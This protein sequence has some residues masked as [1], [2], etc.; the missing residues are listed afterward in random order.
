MSDTT[1][2]LWQNYF[3]KDYLTV[4]RE[5]DKRLNE[6]VIDLHLSGLC[7]A[8][9]GRTQIA[10]T[11]L[12][13][14]ADLSFNQ[15]HMLANA[16]VALL[17]A[18]DPRACEE[19]SRI[20]TE[21]HPKNAMLHFMLGNS[22]LTQ[23]RFAEAVEPYRTSLLL[24]PEHHDAKINL[25]N[26]LRRV[27]GCGAEAKSLY[28][29]V[30]AKDPDRAEAL[31]NLAGMLMDEGHDELAEPLAMRSMQLRPTP[32]TAFVVGMLRL[33]QGRYD[34]GFDLYRE[35]WRCPMTG[36]DRAKMTRPMPDKLADI[37]GKTVLLVH[38]QGFGDTLQ[39][40]RYAPMILPHAK[41]CFVLVPPPLKRLMLAAFG[42]M[43]IGVITDREQIK[44]QH[45]LEIPLLNLPHLLGTKSVDDIPATLPYYKVP[46]TMTQA[47][48]LPP[49][50]PA[51]PLRIGLCWAGQSRPDPDLMATDKR[52]SM[53]LEALAPLAA[54]DGITWFSLQLGEPE[55]QI[56]TSQ[57][58]QGRMHRPLTSNFDF[59]DSAAVIR[60]LDLVIS[61]D[62]SVCHLTGGLNVP[63]WVLSRFDG[64]WRWLR[65]NRSDS[66]W[67][68]KAMRIFRQPVRGDWAT[69]V[70]E[71]ETA[72][73][74]RIGQ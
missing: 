46:E 62:T 24:D 5:T 3:N 34:E 33:G 52:R 42:D 50:D 35:R 69:V 12:L 7:L 9:I 38:E 27:D 13:A 14:A 66:P 29:L 59:L 36:P 57:S 8:G 45:D 61:V 20:G 30:I 25:A 31:L 64:C 21:R 63:V 19:L 48:A 60:Q 17:E 28:E 73:R 67:Y 11:R 68:P 16:A 47:L 44:N 37:W 71:V 2:P 58:W 53:S 1:D 22:L 6:H 41:R 18:D 39:F 23:R 55:T 65:D 56:D 74:E 15:P 49:V 26:A 54:I 72:L 40:I 10:K 43:G 70:K 4:L 32:E 51:R